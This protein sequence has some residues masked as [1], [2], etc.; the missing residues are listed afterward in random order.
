LEY[1]SRLFPSLSEIVSGSP[2]DFDDPND[3][4]GLDLYR[5]TEENGVSCYPLFKGVGEKRVQLP[6]REPNRVPATR[7]RSSSSLLCLYNVE[8]MPA[9]IRQSLGVT[10]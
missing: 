4:V 7:E 9:N 3:S 5:T 1:Y 2:E 6:S 10:K 8:N